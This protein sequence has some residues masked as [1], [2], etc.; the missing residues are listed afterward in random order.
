[1]TPKN[2]REIFN[3]DA[4]VVTDPKTGK[5]AYLGYDLLKEGL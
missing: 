3:I 1:M 2:L 4:D 5:P